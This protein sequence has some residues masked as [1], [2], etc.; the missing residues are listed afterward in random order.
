[1]PNGNASIAKYAGT[2]TFSKDLQ[3]TQV[4]YVPDFHLNLISVPKLCLDNCLV[5]TFDNDNCLIQ[6][7]ETLKMIGLARL[8][9]GLYY[10]TTLPDQSSFVA[11]SQIASTII[12]TEAL[13]HFRLGHLS[14]SRLS[15]LHKQFPYVNVV[16][17]G[18]CDIFHLTRHKKLPYSNSFNKLTMLMM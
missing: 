1:L 12:P 5:V 11:S 6:V 9:E 15:N 4:L 7:K 3:I 13:W 2:I 8:T 17:N 14:N 10:L 16:H 18:I